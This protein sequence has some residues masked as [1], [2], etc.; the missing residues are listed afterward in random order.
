MLSTEDRQQVLVWSEQQP[1]KH[2]SMAFIIEWDFDEIESLIEKTGTG[3]RAEEENY[4]PGVRKPT[5]H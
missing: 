5:W 3:M 2:T 4:Q 1:G